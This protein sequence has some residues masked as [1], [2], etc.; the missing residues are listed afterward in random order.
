MHFSSPLSLQPPAYAIGAYMASWGDHPQ[1][2]TL[3]PKAVSPTRYPALHR[4]ELSSP[5][6]LSAPNSSSEREL[7]LLLLHLRCRLQGTV[8]APVFLALFSVSLLASYHS[9]FLALLS[10]GLFISHIVYCDLFSTDSSSSQ[11]LAP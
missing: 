6:P 1:I 7:L 5:R 9:T 10:V 8:L 11:S 4:A 3:S 2:L